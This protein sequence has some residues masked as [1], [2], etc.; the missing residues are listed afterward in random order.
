MP[1]QEIDRDCIALI[2]RP[3]QGGVPVHIFLVY[4]Y[5]L[6]Q[7]IYERDACFNQ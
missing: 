2:C 6:V 4:R 3:H 5:G 1:Q 7:L